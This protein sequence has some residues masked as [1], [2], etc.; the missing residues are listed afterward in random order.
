MSKT[1]DGKKK[2]I[3]PDGFLP[4]DSN[5]KFV[6]HEAICVLNTGEVDANISLTLYFE[7]REPME[8][9]EVLC[10]AERTNHIRLDKITDSEGKQIPRGVPYA[11][12][13]L[14]D[15]PVVVQHSRMD[16]TQP[17]M[18]LMSTIAY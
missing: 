15:Q 13:V 9:L 16:T 2:W 12:K 17:E 5:G 18:A 7:D 10:A 11:M 1:A 8:G 14:S 4:E 6:S 3:I